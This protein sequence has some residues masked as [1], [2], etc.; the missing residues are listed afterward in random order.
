MDIGRYTVLGPLGRGGMGAVYKVRHQG[1]GRIM[2]LKLLKPHELLVELMG[3]DAVR[4]AFL[5][6][7]RILAAC[8]H[9]NV[10]AVWDLDEDRGWPFMVLEYLCMNVGALIGENR[11]VENP[12]RLV[13]PLT[14]LDFVGQAL[15]GLQYL[16]DLGIVHLDIKPGNLMLGSDGTIKLI[17]LGLSRLR[18]E[19]WVR[20]RGLK[21]GS[22]YYAAP[23]QE[24]HPE[25]AD[26]RAD[27]FAAA[28]VL[29]RLVTG[30]LPVDGTATGTFVSEGWR[31]FFVRALDPDPDRRFQSARHMRQALNALGADLR[32]R[33][34]DGCVFRE[35]V[36]AAPGPLRSTP[37]R[38]GVVS[39][40][41]AFL[42]ELFRPL[43]Y[44][45]A[46]LEEVGDGWLDR[47]SGLIWGP[48][49]PWP[50][51]WD[52]GA[53]FVNSDAATG[54]GW[55]LPTVE[56]LVS[57]LRPVQ[58]LDTFCHR[59]FEDRY[60]WIW[61]ADRRSHTSAWFVDVGGSAVLAQERTCRFHV[62][63]VRG[64]EKFFA[65]TENP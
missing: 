57:L 33:E 60:L 2:A 29:H 46:E 30:V 45:Q 47:C 54:E 34:D 55:R 25:Q 65:P 27:L 56:E 38:T 53:A 9:R 21:I 1:L 48:V 7:A 14:A 17:D 11:V 8:E 4:A 5:R 58:D 6:E 18:G 16:H 61:T 62:R 40:P 51:T 59:P 39:R 64:G 31:E 26:E 52:E 15:D 10:A 20:P 19:P 44:Q 13:P 35:P 42:D 12:T 3:E 22:P 28:V 24:K 43:R 50:M 32:G 63:P 36:C 37:L 49:S 23:E 41:F